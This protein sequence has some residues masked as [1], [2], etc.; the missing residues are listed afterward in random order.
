VENAEWEVIPHCEREYDVNIILY[1]LCLFT[2]T[3][4][5]MVFLDVMLCHLV[6]RHQFLRGRRL[7][8]WALVLVYHTTS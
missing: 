2:F 1:L 3:F 7:V 5:I 6:D 4:T 8:R